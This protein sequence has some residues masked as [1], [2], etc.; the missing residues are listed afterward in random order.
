VE[1]NYGTRVVVSAPGD[2][3]MDMTLS[4]DVSLYSQKFGWTSG[5]T[6][7][8]AGV[9][10]MM[11]A[12]NQDLSPAQVK[13]ILGRVGDPVASDADKPAGRFLNAD[14]AVKEAIAQG[15]Q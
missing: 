6:P 8:V 13:E 11:L 12:V 14:L 3:Y 7:K 5:A 15:T 2:P 9:V 4:S 1:S 10:A